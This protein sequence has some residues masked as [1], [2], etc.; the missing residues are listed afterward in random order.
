MAH[1]FLGFLLDLVFPPRCVFCGKLLHTGER[2]ICASCQRGLPWLVG[3]AAEQT[4]E[5]FTLCASPLRYQDAVR[6]SL[7]RYKF[8]GQKAYAGA[9]GKLVA[10]CVRDHLKGRYDVI[11]WVPLSEQRLKQRGYDQAMLL[12][13]AVALELGGVAVETLRKRR[14]T[15]AQSGISGTAERRANVLDAYEVIDPELVRGRRVLLIDDIITTG[16]TISECAHTL[17]TIGATD[18]VCATLARAH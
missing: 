11:S 10:Q 8:R 3:Q 2:E 4:G 15:S 16:S 1:G 14:N 12:A 17:R 6:A 18:A 13:M 5:D 9:Y 7:H